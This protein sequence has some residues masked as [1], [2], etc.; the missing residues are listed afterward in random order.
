[1]KARVNPLPTLLW[2]ELRKQLGWLMLLGGIL[3]LS[4]VVA[5]RVRQEAMGQPL[6]SVGGLF[7]GQF[8]VFITA[9]F[10]GFLLLLAA[11]GRAGR[12]ES[13]LLLS[14]PPGLIHQLARFLFAGAVLLVFAEALA[15]LFWW[16][17]RGFGLEL[18]LPGVLGLALYGVILGL[19]LLALALLGQTLT[20]AYGLSRLGWLSG[21][22][23]VL[24]IVALL[25][26][27]FELSAR[28]AYA[29]LPVWP[30][31]A[32]RF[33]G[34]DLL[35]EAPVAG[36]PGEPLLY[37]LLL[38]ALGIVLAGRIWDEVEA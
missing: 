35:A 28:T 9:A 2:L 13:W 22:A 10:A 7:A 38:T 8:A 30:F 25:G 14:V 26:W 23:L 16:G 19:P 20:W 36:L 3:L 5:L 27:F 18:S 34:V 33:Q 6:D 15:G 37:A 29:F 32:V 12:V 21:A 17:T 4:L 31:P 11:L 1:M 24:G